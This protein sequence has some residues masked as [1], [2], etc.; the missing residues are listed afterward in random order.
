[1]AK[2][3]FTEVYPLSLLRNVSSAKPVCAG[4]G[5]SGYEAQKQVSFPVTASR[6]RWAS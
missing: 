4:K 2:M 1:M 5:H 3:T 6:E